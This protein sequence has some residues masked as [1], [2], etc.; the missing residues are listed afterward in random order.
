VIDTFAGF[1]HGLRHRQPIQSAEVSRFYRHNFENFA[2]PWWI[3]RPLP[4]LIR[5]LPREMLRREVLRGPKPHPD[6]DDG[7]RDEYLAERARL[8]PDEPKT[9][10]F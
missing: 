2:S 6:G 9:L 10:Q 7:R 1:A 3:S 5:S 4:E 8:Y